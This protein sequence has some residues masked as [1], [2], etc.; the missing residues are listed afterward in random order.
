MKR[1]TPQ[2][3][4]VRHALQELEKS[5]ERQELVRRSLSQ[6]LVH[7]MTGAGVANTVGAAEQYATGAGAI[8]STT[9]TGAAQH[10]RIRRNIFHDKSWS[11]NVP[12]W[13][14]LHHRS[15]YGI[16]CQIWRNAS[17]DRSWCGERNRP[18]RGAACRWLWVWGPCTVTREDATSESRAIGILELPFSKFSILFKSTRIRGT[19]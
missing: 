16:H 17:H 1:C 9:G 15:W 4:Q 10:H 14:W 6:A 2:Q 12:H 7:S 3:K 5:I 19:L 18:W 8:N 13:R 11:S